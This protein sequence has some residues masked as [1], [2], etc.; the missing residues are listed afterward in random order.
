MGIH[1]RLCCM[2][3]EWQPRN[4]GKAEHTILPDRQIYQAILEDS[5]YHYKSITIRSKI[6]IMITSTFLPY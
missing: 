6:G 2:W 1:E 5:T 3:E 4:G